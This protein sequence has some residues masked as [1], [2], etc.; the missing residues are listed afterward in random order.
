MD[1]ALARQ[2]AVLRSEFD[3]IQADIKLGIMDVLV[4]QTEVLSNLTKL[5]ENIEE[6]GV[7]LDST[8][9]VTLSAAFGARDKVQ[10]LLQHFGIG[11]S[12]SSTFGYTTGPSSSSPALE[13]QPSISIPPPSTSSP[14]PH[15]S[16]PSSPTFSFPSPPRTTSFPASTSTP[17]IVVLPSP[18]TPSTEILPSPSISQ[19]TASVLFPSTPPVIILPPS[20]PSAAPLVDDAK[21]GEEEKDV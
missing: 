20:D 14:A 11:G 16:P 2:T 9:S 13:V 10:Q 8:L 12:S 1:A 18:L 6:Q 5:K 21:G 15:V 4:A 17:A 3:T 19:P 7:D